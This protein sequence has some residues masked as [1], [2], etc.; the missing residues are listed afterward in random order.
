MVPSGFFNLYT[1]EDIVLGSGITAVVRKGFRNTDF[2]DKV[3]VK[4]IS[5]RNKNLREDKDFTYEVDL[6]KGLNHP[7]IVRARE[8]FENEHFIYI[9][10][11]FSNHGDLCSYIRQR[12]ALSEE[13]SKTWFHILL[14][15]ISYLHTNDIIHRDLKPENILLHKNLD[16]HIVLRV[17]DFGVSRFL[18]V[19]S[20]CKTF[21]GTVLFRAPEVVESSGYT[22]Q[23][24]L[25]SCGIILYV[26]LNGLLP[27]N[28]TSVVSPLMVEELA[29]EERWK[30]MPSASNLL[31]RL[32]DFK[33][34]NRL[35][36]DEALY[37][38]WFTEISE[39]L[40]PEA[41]RQ[42]RK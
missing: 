26:M 38:P 4:I 33:P 24:D 30:S 16:G 7:N 21:A 41:K 12:G 32:L 5:K 1:L 18:K 29:R 25:W 36:L 3:A 15:A 20:V 27:F 2:T 19:D 6:L 39:V 35:K 42:K 22:K 9:V 31:F 23:A 8:Y 40:Q 34:A 11:D 28:A 14:K 37:H 10:M 13:K 17:G